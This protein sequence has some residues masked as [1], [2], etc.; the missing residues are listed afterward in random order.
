M[1]CAPPELIALRASRMRPWRFS[2]F[3][4]AQKDD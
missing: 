4:I 2:M 3:G 1:V